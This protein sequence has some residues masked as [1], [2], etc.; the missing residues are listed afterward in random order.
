MKY[1]ARINEKEYEIEILSETRVLINGVH[2]QLDFQVLEQLSYSLLVDGIS[3]ETY[4]FQDNGEWEVLLSAKQYSVVIEDERE[5][6]LRLATGGVSHTT[7]KY[8]LSAPMPGLVIDIPVEVGSQVSKGDVLVILE[9][10]KMQNELTAPQD[11]TVTRI[12]V[13]VSDNVER[14]E[15]LLILI[16]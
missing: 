12:N 13:E 16:S 1:F 10:M 15:S 8:I 6:Q 5:R 9:S 11:G 7:G 14:K 4:L 2:H 3:Y